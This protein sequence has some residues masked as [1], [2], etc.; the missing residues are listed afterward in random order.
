M[1]VLEDLQQLERRIVERAGEL[2]AAVD[3][4]EELRQAASRLGIDLGGEA[5]TRRPVPTNGSARSSTRAE[6]NG[7]SDRAPQPKTRPKAKAKP[8]AR[9]SANREQ[10]V[11]GS[12]RQ[13]GSRR[14]DVIRLIDQRPGITVA[15][16]GQDLGVNPTGLY[17]VIR[18]LESAGKLEKEG[19]TL[20]PSGR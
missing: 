5:V 19:R 4:Y 16:V 14:D 10:R 8:K 2:R 18:D 17:R 11:P 12:S 20:R 7:T 9:A 3:E 6:A 1:S 13:R 15:D